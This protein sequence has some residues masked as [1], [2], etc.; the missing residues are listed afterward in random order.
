V[1]SGYL[2]DSSALLALHLNESGYERVMPLMDEAAIH[3]ITVADV[4][5]KLVQKGV[6]PKQARAILEHLDLVTIDA[7]TFEQACLCGR[8]H[9]A[10]RDLGLSLGDCICLTAAGSLG[11]TAVTAD[12]NWM[13]AGARASIPVLCIR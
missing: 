3:S 5:T 8:L 12:R 4:V 2:L 11:R 9:A 7:L 1:S 10:T 13:E 6:P